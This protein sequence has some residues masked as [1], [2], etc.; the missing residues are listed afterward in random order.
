MFGLHSNIYKLVILSSFFLLIILGLHL[1]DNEGR[2]FQSSAVHNQ[3]NL[4]HKLS[5]KSLNDLRI[6]CLVLTH[7]DNH[8]TK[9]YQVFNTW[10]RRCTY[11]E[12]LTSEPDDG[13][14]TIVSHSREEYDLVW[15]KTKLGFKTAYDKYY[16]KVDWVMK[17]D[18]DTY[19]IMENLRY[20]LSSYSPREPIWLGCVLKVAEVCLDGLDEYMMGGAGYVLSKEAVRR[21]NEISLQNTSFCQQDDKGPEDLNMGNCLKGVGVVSRGST[22]MN[23]RYLFLPFFP[24]SKIGQKDW[25]SYGS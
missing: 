4:E 23:N 17:A 16:D 19:V 2:K 3:E 14:P 22:D 13:I 5:T 15:A 9:A 10:G 24:H 8:K 11:I 7:P 6:L 21:F 18:D 12:F 20:L 1:L 25:S